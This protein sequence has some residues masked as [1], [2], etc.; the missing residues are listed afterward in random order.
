MLVELPR[1]E[2]QKSK[3]GA[4]A[5]PYHVPQH[6]WFAKDDVLFSLTL[7][8]PAACT[9]PVSVTPP[10]AWEEC[11]PCSTMT[12]RRM[13]SK[14]FFCARQSSGRERFARASLALALRPGALSWAQ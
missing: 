7:V 1:E 2:P 9:Q 12:R 4:T 14:Y 6:A 3:K 13:A 5:V 8:L 11:A 10:Q